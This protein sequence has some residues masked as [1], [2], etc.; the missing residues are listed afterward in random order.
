MKFWVCVN[1]EISGPLEPAAAVKVPGF[2]LFAWACRELPTGGRADEP[3]AWKR[4]ISFPEMAAHFFPNYPPPAQ[5]LETPVQE[6]AQPP[7]PVHSLPSV[8]PGP[9]RQRMAL[10]PD[11][12]LMR[13]INRK[14]DDLLASRAMAP[15]SGEPLVSELRRTGEIM[16]KLASGSGQALHKEL[17]PLSRKLDLAEKT[18]S[19]MK[20]GLGKEAL[21]LELEPLTRTLAVTEKAVED[22]RRDMENHIGGELGPL[23]AAIELAE[24]AIEAEDA[25]IALFRQEVVGRL[26]A[27][28]A[29]LKEFRVELAAGRAIAEAEA[30]MRQPLPPATRRSIRPVLGAALGAAALLLVMNLSR[31][32]PVPDTVK[33]APPVAAQAGPAVKP[34]VTALDF[35]R[36]YHVSPGGIMLADAIGR[37]ASARGGA[38][39]GARWEPEQVADSYFR[40]LVSVPRAGGGLLP[41]YFGLY[42]AEGR[43]RAL[44]KGARRA[45]N[46]LSAPGPEKL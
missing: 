21:H 44:N 8:P 16:E 22:I 38:P 30:L 26:S 13:E 40:L 41:Y 25:R 31:K 37:D 5:I 39:T 18:F 43:V 11:S 45:L 28:E 3:R 46:L 23:K 12:A 7:A 4:A 32:E 35:A 36:S 24:K 15:Q 2:T 34:E 27:L 14:L 29:S 10:E 20:S 9:P 33:P 6:A 1:N 42:P 17:E 19:E